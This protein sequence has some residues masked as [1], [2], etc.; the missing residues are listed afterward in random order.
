MY[1]RDQYPWQ[2]SGQPSTLVEICARMGS[3]RILPCCRARRQK[4]SRNCDLNPVSRG[5]GSGGESGDILIHK[6]LSNR[7]TFLRKAGGTAKPSFTARSLEQMDRNGDI[8][9]Q[10]LVI[11]NVAGTMFAGKLD[12]QY[13]HANFTN[14]HQILTGGADTVR[15]IQTANIMLSQSSRQRSH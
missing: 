1:F 11:E 7:L 13:Y 12:D 14:R 9:F 3:W 10:E 5:Q 15:S 4:I 2:I 6:R 8:E